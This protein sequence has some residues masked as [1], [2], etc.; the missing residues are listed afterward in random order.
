MGVIRRIRYVTAVMVCVAAISLSLATASQASTAGPSATGRSATPALPGGLRVVK[1]P[2]SRA[3]AHPGLATGWEYQYSAFLINPKY[4]Y[5]LTLQPS[6]S[7]GRL[8]NHLYMW[9]LNNWNT[10]EWAIYSYYNTNATIFVSAYNGLCINVPGV[11]TTSGTQL[12]AYTCTA[13]A[14][15]PGGEAKNEVFQLGNG[16]AGGAVFLL[17]YDYNLAIS[18][19][20]NFP[21]NGAWVI[22][23]GTNYYNAEENWGICQPGPSCSRIVRT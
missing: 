9:A 19:G 20:S 10:Q 6:S 18:I 13:S 12:I 22:I 2:R 21:G 5:A 17:S 11:S 8:E 4:D 7:S 16:S 15:G 14:E 1:V 3:A 23:Y